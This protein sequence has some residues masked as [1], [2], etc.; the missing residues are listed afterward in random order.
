[1]KVGMKM[2]TYQIQKDGLEKENNTDLK[3]MPQHIPKGGGR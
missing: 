2:V 1:M 3:N